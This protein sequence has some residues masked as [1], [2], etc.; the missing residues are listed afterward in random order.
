MVQ[1]IKNQPKNNKSKYKGLLIGSVFILI[2]CEKRNCDM[3][4]PGKTH[5]C[6]VEPYEIYSGKIRSNSSCVGDRYSH[7]IIACLK[8]VKEVLLLLLLLIFFGGGRLVTNE[9]FSCKRSVS[10]GLLDQCCMF[11][12]RFLISSQTMKHFPPFLVVNHRLICPERNHKTSFSSRKSD[13]Y[14]YRHISSLI[15]K[16]DHHLTEKQKSSTFPREEKKPSK[17][18]R[19]HHRE[20]P[21]PAGSANKSLEIFFCHCSNF[22]RAPKNCSGFFSSFH[23]FFSLKFSQHVNWW[24]AF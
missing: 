1:S 13:T 8:I 24:V 17:K 14:M 9:R 18:R 16:K 21:L 7:F 2:Y 20:E 4:L 22:P 15:F 5:H 6:I 12:L 23:P 10:L 3:Q 19:L 11:F